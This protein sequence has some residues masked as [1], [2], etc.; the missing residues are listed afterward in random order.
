MKIINKDYFLLSVKSRN[1]TYYSVGTAMF[2]FCSIE[3]TKVAAETLA[4]KFRNQGESVIIVY[5][6]KIKM[7]QVLIGSSKLKRNKK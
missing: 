1:K 6:P 3:N 4:K 7:Y 2:P 5:Y